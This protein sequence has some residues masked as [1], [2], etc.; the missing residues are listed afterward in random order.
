VKSPLVLFGL[1]ICIQAQ[2]QQPQLEAHEAWVDLDTNELVINGVNFDNGNLL[3]VTLGDV[4]LTVVPSADPS[5]AATEIRAA[6]PAIFSPG[7]YTVLITSGGGSIRY[8]QIDITVGNTGPRGPEGPPGPKGDRGAAGAKGDTGEQGPRGQD[9]DDCAV[10]PLFDANGQP[11]GAEVTCGATVAQIPKGDKGDKGE[12]GADGAQGLTG[13]PGLACWDANGNGSPDTDE[14]LN[15]DAIVD[16]KDCRGEKGLAGASGAEGISCWDLNRDGNR[17]PEED[18]NQDGQTDVLDCAGNVDLS[19]L[20]L[21]LAAVE[22]RAAFIDTDG[23]RVSPAHG[24]CDDNNN[25]VGGLH[26]IT[27]TP[28]ED[29]PDDGL[30]NDCDG[31]VDN[32]SAGGTQLIDTDGDGLSDQYE[33]SIGCSPLSK[34]TDND[35]L[36]DRKFWTV[37]YTESVRYQCGTEDFTGAAIYCWRDEP[38][39][40]YKN[41]PNVY[42]YDGY[43]V[44]TLGTKCNDA[45]TDDD[46]Y[47]DGREVE[48]GT[49][50]LDPASFPTP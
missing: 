39:Y 27:L 36:L 33:I 16:V 12:P 9:G 20:I 22:S 41:L 32:P 2:A 50:P 25:L 23:D 26:P 14:D 7:T 13:T 3:E 28:Y 29:I 8:D 37:L 1:I 4:P 48:L 45:D 24:D 17:D 40:G 21:R 38:V 49:D 15:G 43:E 34:D 18:L 47:R 42:M 30:D 31:T 35:S 10:A 5:L 6:M 19:S 44:N 11:S 46:G